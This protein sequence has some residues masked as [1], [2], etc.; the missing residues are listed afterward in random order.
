MEIKGNS[1]MTMITAQQAAEKWGTS[2]RNVQDLCKRGRIVGAERWGAAWMIPAD[3]PKPVDGRSRLAK[4]STYTLPLLRNSPFLNMTDLYKVPGSAED[5]ISAL[6]AYPETQM[7]MRSQMAY[8]QGNLQQVI[9]A[10]QALLNTRSSIYA[11]TATGLTLGKCAVW[12]GDAALYQQAKQYL[13]QASWNTETE[14]ELLVLAIA[15]LDNTFRS[16]KDYP[17]WF[18]RGCLDALH[19]DAFPSA[20]VLYCQFLMS[21]SQESGLAAIKSNAGTPSMRNIIFLVEP[22]ISQ[23]SANGILLAEIYLRLICAICYNQV[24]LNKRAGQHIERAIALAVPDRLVEPFVIYRKQLGAT[25]DER[26]AAA[27]PEMA[28]MVKEMHRQYTAGWTKL[29]TE[30]LQRSAQYALSAK[31]REVSRLAA[32]GMRNSLIAKQLNLAESAVAAIVTQVMSKTGAK[33]RT[34]L[35]QYM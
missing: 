15:A 21:V 34:E 2:L 12:S 19:A 1:F 10:S 7:L 6:D 20:F 11:A 8:T 32:F 25:M 31:E 14:R 33:N 28:M 13:Y 17:D 30:V 16:A 5:A 26:L 3:A 35:G 4:E 9:D 24:G 29:R 23:V 18:E 22:L 27:D